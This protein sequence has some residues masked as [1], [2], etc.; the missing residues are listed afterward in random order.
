MINFSF[1]N[2]IN[3]LLIFNFN[4]LTNLEFKFVVK[5]LKNSSFLYLYKYFKIVEL[6]L[7]FS[8]LCE[9]SLQSVFSIF[10]KFYSNNKLYSFDMHDFKFFF[11]INC[12]Q[13]IRKKNLKFNL[14]NLYYYKEKILKKNKKSLLSLYTFGNIYKEHKGAFIPFKV[15]NLSWFVHTGLKQEVKLIIIIF[16]FIIFLIF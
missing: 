5:F 13:L 11:L 4:N 9:R 3:S 2:N 12:I 8:G 1:Y 14:K 7:R 10:S 16:Y 6:N 15:T